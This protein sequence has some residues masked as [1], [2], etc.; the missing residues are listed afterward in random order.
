VNYVAFSIKIANMWVDKFFYVICTM[1]V[2][3]CML[4]LPIILKVST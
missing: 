4:E 2:V 3:V 1:F